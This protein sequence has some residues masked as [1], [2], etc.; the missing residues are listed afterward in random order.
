MQNTS[1]I[2]RI[3]NFQPLKCRF[4]KWFDVCDKM[5]YSYKTG[6]WSYSEEVNT[7]VWTFSIWKIHT[8]FF[9]ILDTPLNCIIIKAKEI[10]SKWGRHKL[11][12]ILFSVPRS[13][14]WVLWRVGR[15]Q[16][17]LHRHVHRRVRPQDLIVWTQGENITTTITIVVI[18]IT[19]PTLLKF[20]EREVLS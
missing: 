4:C 16:P 14:S 12:S 2:F 11:N 15:P 9:W 5:S 8:L 3:R 10:W 13:S 6:T 20:L 7:F 18:I 19:K 17:D 1:K